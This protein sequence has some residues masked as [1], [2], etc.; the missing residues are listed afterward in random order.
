MRFEEQ[1]LHDIFSQIQNR[2]I[3]VIGDVMLDRYI[4]GKVSR[5]SPEAPVPVVDVVEESNHLGGAS[6]VALNIRS[7]G[8][9]PVLFGVVG[10][11]ANARE[12]KSIFE[13]EKIITDFLVEDDARPTTVKTRIIAGSQ[14]VARIDYEDRQQISE[15]T[16]RRVIDRLEN[17]IGSIE[18]IILQ[19]YNKGV[20]GPSLIHQVIELA[21]KHE[22][23]VLVDPKFNNFFEYQGVS[24]FKPNRNETEDALKIKLSDEKSFEEAARTLRNRL[25]SEHVLLTLGDKGMLLLKNDG[26]I[27]RVAT[28]ARNVADV[29]GAGDTVIA[30]LAVAMASGATLVEAAHIANFAGG[31]VCEE[32]GIVPVDRDKLYDAALGKLGVLD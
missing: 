12:L 19:D 10:E 21:Q 22:I 27:T 6:N 29:S 13:H 32:V 16:T 3:A 5:I 28:R 8:A 17:H 1:R 7:L 30:T 20:I 23:P 26:E 18:I 9:V 15:D 11:D 25:N 4:W 24:V 2:F 31:L 14:H